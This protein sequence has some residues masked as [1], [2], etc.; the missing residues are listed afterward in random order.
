MIDFTT[1]EQHA[2]SKARNVHQTIWSL[3]VNADETVE[4]FNV[5]DKYTIAVTLKTEEMR[6][7][8]AAGRNGHPCY[9]AAGVLLYRIRQDAPAIVQEA[10]TI[11]LTSV[12]LEDWFQTWKQKPAQ[13]ICKACEKRAAGERGL[14]YVCERK[15]RENAILYQD[16]R[17]FSIYRSA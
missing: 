9:H 10:L 3:G 5:S 14:C 13:P 6:C 7:T 16:D 15:Q 4:F 11:S 1:R 17:P 12:V 2:M 8:C